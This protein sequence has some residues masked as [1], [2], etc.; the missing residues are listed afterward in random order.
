[1]FGRLVK[2]VQVRKE[3]WGLL[4]YAQAQH[5]ICFVRSGDWLEPQH[6]N[7]TWTLSGLVAD[8]TQRLGTP[9][10]VTERSIQKTTARLVE[11]GMIIDEPR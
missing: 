11:S 10:D 1:M 6:F 7:G 4:F 2:G 9:A 3:G 8:I 5:R